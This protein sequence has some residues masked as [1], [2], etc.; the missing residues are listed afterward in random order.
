M[1]D[2]SSFVRRINKPKVQFAA[3]L[4]EWWK[5]ADRILITHTT[6][7]SLHLSSALQH[8]AKSAVT[9]DHDF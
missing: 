2:S 4:M 6:S 8:P 1:L 5:S 9:V 3:L 7:I